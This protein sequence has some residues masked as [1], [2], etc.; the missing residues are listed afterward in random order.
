MENSLLGIVLCYR[1]ELLSGGHN[2]RCRTL[3]TWRDIMKTN[4]AKHNI[5]KT[6]F[7]LSFLLALAGCG[8]EEK[9]AASLD[10]AAISK[11]EKF[12]CANIAVSQADFEALGFA[13]GDSCSIAFSNGVKYDDVP[14]YNGYYVKNGNPVLVAYPGSKTLLFTLSNTGIWDQANLNENC[15]I[16]VTL[17]AKAKYLATQ[18]AL[19]Q[20]YPSDRSVYASDEEFAN[21]RPLSG[22]RLKEDFIYR[23][24]SPFDNSH[25]RSEIVDSLLEKSKIKTIVDLADSSSDMASYIADSSYSFP[26]SEALYEEGNV[27]LLGMGS[28]YASDSY[29]Q[30]VAK[31]IRHM[32]SKQ[33]PY[34][35]HC[36]EGKD[37]TGFVCT[38]IEALAGATYYEMRDDYMQTYK[39]YYK[40]TEEKTKEKY[41]AIVSLYFDSFCECLHGEEETAKL[42]K[43]SYEEDAK[44]YLASG[45]LSETEIA[46]FGK[47]ICQEM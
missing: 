27:V 21:F 43:A 25:N 13:L 40:I 42:Q 19:G 47:L 29:K 26:Y 2:A 24:A 30:S 7:C 12:L 1:K 3:I 10:R 14:Y 32:L 23:G 11:D 34:Y 4:K 28:G 31:G 5:S 44:R 22:G 6:L 37:R 41:D 35:I 15:T 46:S 36:M 17:E 38:L 33:K 20:S 16:S 39:N 8:S 9:K 18:E 45:G